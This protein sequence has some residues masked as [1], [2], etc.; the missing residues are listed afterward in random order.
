MMMM[1]MTPGAVNVDC[2]IIV[3]VYNDVSEVKPKLLYF[4][5]LWIVQQIHIA[6]PSHSRLVIESGD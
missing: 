4:D 3:A 1:M 2:V 5:L 6:T